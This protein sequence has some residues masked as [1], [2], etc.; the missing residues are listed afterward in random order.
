MLDPPDILFVRIP[1]VQRYVQLRHKYVHILRD[2]TVRPPE[3]IEP[4]V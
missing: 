4:Y 2:A 3:S 1:M